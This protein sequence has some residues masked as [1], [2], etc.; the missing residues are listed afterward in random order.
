MRYL[1]TNPKRYSRRLADGPN[2]HARRRIHFPIFM[3]PQKAGIAF[4]SHGPNCPPIAPKNARNAARRS[5]APP[6]FNRPNAPPF[7][8]PQ[9]FKVLPGAGK[10]LGSCHC[11]T[12]RVFNGRKNKGVKRCLPVIGKPRKEGAGAW[13]QFG[14][15]RV[16]KKRPFLP[17]H[18]LA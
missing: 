13:L 18:G 5:I 8:F 7:T 10:V 2:G 12:A 15:N 17:K 6:P 16:A 9:P 14:C 11:P 1:P 4:Y 3:P